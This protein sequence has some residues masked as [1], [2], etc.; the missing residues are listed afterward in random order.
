[1]RLARSSIAQGSSAAG[2]LLFKT[3]AYPGWALIRDFTI[4][5][6]TENIK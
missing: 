5:I 2:K 3:A 1:M 4:V 6:V